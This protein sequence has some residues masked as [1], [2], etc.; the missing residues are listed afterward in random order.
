[1]FG[2]KDLIGTKDGQSLSLKMPD[3]LGRFY[4]NTATK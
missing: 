4:D 2:N 1:M 3:H